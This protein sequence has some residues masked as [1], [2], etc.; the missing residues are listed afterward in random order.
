MAAACLLLLPPAYAQ[1]AEPPSPGMV[2]ET[3][4]EPER[5]PVDQEPAPE[6]ETTERER[7]QVPP[8][9]RPVPVERF[10]IT[11][12]TLLSDA[13]MQDVLSRYEGEAHTL[14]EIYAI[15]D[16][17]TGLYRDRG[18]TLANV[19]VPAQRVDQG[20]VRLE[21]IEGRIDSLH[22]EG[23]E[24]YRTETILRQLDTLDTGRA[25][26]ARDLESE[27]LRLNDMPGLDVRA[28]VKPG[29]EYGT[30]DITFRVNET[31]AS[32]RF[33]TDNHGRDSIGEHRLSADATLNSLTGRGDRL[34]ANVLVSESGLLKYGQL[35]WGFPVDA[36]GGR[37]RG[38]YSDA[39]YE[40]SGADFDPLDIEGSNTSARVDY[41]R[42]LLRTRTDTLLVGVALSHTETDTDSLGQRIAETSLTL[43]EASLYYSHIGENRSVS[44]VSAS[45]AT[46]FR[47]NPDGLPRNRQ[48]GR[49]RLDGNTSIPFADNN[50]L[51]LRAGMAYSP[52]PLADTQKFSVGGPH[53][54]RGYLPSEARGD[55]GYYLST[56]LS[57][58]FALGE[59]P[60]SAGTFIEYA[61]IKRKALPGDGPDVSRSDSLAN[62]GVNFVINPAGTFRLNSTWAKPL[63]GHPDST[64]S[65]KPRFWMS[66]SANF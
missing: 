61:D 2:E 60:A 58:M 30:S 20:V 17:L 10:E 34:R 4:R 62:W 7:E 16:H 64:G 40:V 63:S 11:G 33:A 66:L 24:R 23:N 56:E 36:A 18:Y 37:L 65:T 55:S 22:V 35:A 41:L 21:V 50:L 15:A 47:D 31:P 42:P 49:F 9:G 43:Y 48:R 38:S 53:L 28:V 52:E 8:G 57:R 5:F 44:S 13:E 54:L 32:Y 39:R 25:F 19:M 27:I 45:I 46:N 3:L 29:A 26:R 51:I 12:N 1:E 14:E 59:V 6:I